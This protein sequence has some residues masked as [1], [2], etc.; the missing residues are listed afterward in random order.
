MLASAP[1]VS[2]AED[3]EAAAG[4]RGRPSAPPRL[5]LFAVWLIATS[6]LL[7]VVICR[8]D[9]VSGAVDS[10]VETELRTP[11]TSLW[12]H[13][14]LQAR[15][16][17][18]PGDSEE[19]TPADVPVDPNTGEPSSALQASALR[20]RQRFEALWV[21]IAAPAQETS[22]WLNSHL[23][24]MIPPARHGEVASL[25]EPANIDA[26]VAGIRA[27]LSSPLFAV[28]ADPGAAYHL[29]RR[30]AGC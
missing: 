10:L 21:P 20:I 8:G 28:A 12:V 5:A 16:S 24:Y 29:R 13:L 7:S 4:G 23:L 22:A 1:I 19:E 3:N 14:E 11:H 30:R 15:G 17:S 25:L 26:A 18:A 27:R 9:L 2:R 6:V